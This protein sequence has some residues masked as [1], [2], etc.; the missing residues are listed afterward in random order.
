M[1]TKPTLWAAA[2]LAI[3]TLQPSIAQDRKAPPAPLDRLQ[4][5]DGAR[6]VPD[7]FLRRWDPVTVFFDRDLGPTN[8]GPEDQ[9]DRFVRLDPPQPGAWQ[10]LGAR[11]LQF[12]P[13]EAWQ[14][15]RR[16]RLLLDGNATTLV[17]LLP[18]PRAVGPD[19]ARSGLADFDSFTL[20]F[21]EPVDVASLRRLLSVEIRPLPGIDATGGQVLSDRDYEIKVAERSDRAGAQTYVVA[22]RQPIADGQVAILRLKLADE[23]GLDEPLFEMR[24]QS[25]VPFAVTSVDCA[26]RASTSRDGVM[27]CLS[28]P[29]ANQ[30]G[31]ALGLTAP[32]QVPDIVQARDALRITPPVDDLTVGSSYGRLQ[33]FGRFKTDTLYEIEIAAGALKDARG[34]PLARPLASTKFTF[35]GDEPKLAWD[36]NQGIVERLG[37]QMVPLRGRGYERADIR[38]HPI[39]GLSRDFWPFPSGRVETDDDAKPPLPGNEPDG[40]KGAD[41]IRRD[42]MVARIK[43]LGSPAVSELVALPIQRG[44]LEAKFG[45]DLKPLLS[46]IAGPDQPGTYLVGIRAVDGGPRRWVRIQVTDLVLSGVEEADRVRFYATSLASAAPVAQAELRLEGVDSN[47]RFTT[48]AR[49]V[50]EA[51]GSFTWSSPNAKSQLRR[52]V[53]TKGA[54]TL[55]LE[56]GRAP[57]QYTRENW[58]KTD[59]NWLSW[60][61]GGVEPRRE[62]VQTL[63]HV[64]T[65]RPIY[66]PEEP[67]HIK[68][69]VRRYLKGGLN[70]ASTEGT[71]V[72]NG[73]GD[74]EWRLPVSLDEVGGF[75]QK[76]DQ[77]TEATGDYSVRFEPKNGEAC[78][79]ITFKKEAYRLP[80]FEVLL[81]GPQ[82]VPLDGQ[83][84]VDM[85]ARYFAGGLVAGRPIKWRATQF[86]YAWTPPKRDGFLFSTDSR[87][88]GD[89]KFRS[90]P[91]LER[92][93]KTDDGGSAKLTLDPT[94]EPTAQPRRYV[95]EATVT[96]EDDIQVRNTQSIVALPPFVLGVKIPRYLPKPGSIE[97]EFLA[98][99][100]NGEAIEGVAMTLRLI[101]RNW[102][103]VLQAS[104]FSQGSAKY[105]TEVIDETLAE[106]KIASTKEVQKALFEAKEAG[107]YLVELEAEDKLGRKQSVSID[108]FMAGDTPVTWSKPPAKT[109]TVTS[110]KDEYAPGESATL[111]VQ[112]PFQTGRAL[113]V[114][115]DPSGRFRYDWIDIANGFGRYQVT[116]AKEQMP[117]LAVHFLLMR[118]RLND[119][120][121]GP[122]A[123]FDL[124]KPVTLAATKWVTVTAVKHK[125]LVAFD[126]PSKARPA[127]EVE[128]VLKL[129]DDTGAPVAG[130]ATFWMVDQA[131][132]SLAR[133]QPLDPLPNF[134]VARPTRM[135]ARDSRNMAFGIIPLEEA[136][137]GDEAVDDWGIE[138][139]SVRKNF[140][141][142][143]IYL[144]RVKVGPDGIA[145]IKVKLPDTL[146]VY[147][148]RA[149]AI[150]GPDRFGFGTGEM[151]IRQPVVAQPALPR[152][153]RSGD[154]FEAGLI[155]RIV[156]GPGGTGKGAFSGTNLTIE[157][158]REQAF[159]WTPNQPARL[160]FS[161]VAGE[162]GP[163]IDKSLIRFL[164]QRDADKAADAVEIALPIRPDRSVLRQ[165]EIRDLAPSAKLEI[166]PPAE[167]ARPGTY[168]RGVTLAGDPALARMIGGLN[169]LVE[170]PY[171]C[172]EQRIALASAAL[173]LKPFKAILD[174]SGLGDQ[175]SADVKLALRSID[176]AIDDD[177]LVGFW[178]RSKG[179]VSLTAWAFGF[180]TAAERAGEPVDAAL[181]DR[182]AKV[183]KQALR[184]D[185]PRLLK[186]EELRE[187]VEALSALADA[188]QIDTAYA[189]ELARRASAMP[190]PTLAQAIGAVARLPVADKRLLAEM[191]D[192]MWGR[193][194]LVQRN[195]KPSY[196]GLSDD[197]PGNPLILPSETRTLAEITQA[198]ALA[199]PGDDRLTPVRDGL[200]RLGDGDGWGSTNANAAAL[201]A[202]ATV[203]SAPKAPT[204]IALTLPAGPETV[205]LGSAAP[206]IR[207]TT[208]RAAPIS[209]EN[210]GRDP[211][212]A[213]VDTRYLPVE[214]GDKAKARADGF[215]VTRGSYRVVAGKPLEKLAAEPDGALHLAVGEVIED[216]A[217]L[218]VPEDRTHVALRMPLAAGLE[219]LNPNLATAP[220]EAAPSAPP[221]LAPTW[222]AYRDDE[223]LFVYNEL[224]KGNYRFAVRGRAT[225]P[226]S[227]TQPPAEAE[228]MY[229]PGITGSSDGARLVVS[230]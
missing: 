227:F 54:D 11:T 169:Y 161:A 98:T 151:Q 17:P 79:K 150:S 167:A 107:V 205:S 149:K 155:G 43:A 63:C 28:V 146:T 15:L 25:A 198:I 49:G 124:G 89:A 66:R 204:P 201:K 222:V 122:T 26:S 184:S 181:K 229:R 80:T 143:P 128:V 121:P 83:F 175:V 51:D 84:A 186:G 190:T 172:T 173:A 119:S 117:K 141:P 108:V 48:L 157:G 163:G 104:D 129:T 168:Q 92:D 221:T 1:M 179:T 23:A 217:E 200:V 142:I 102:N 196:A 50:T 40:W 199:A 106:R 29:G 64:F 215:V 78:G 87:F 37:P 20:T 97:P 180:V 153:L 211:V 34:R 206:A 105:V 144:P 81:N 44:G 72:V 218:V 134:V 165:R 52:I 3:L 192:G 100:A 120:Q 195:G 177:G 109:V 197:R 116:V 60:A 166:A 8:G 170:Y 76:F 223:V 148:L 212:L 2:A 58:G 65:E 154:R 57:P 6:I 209:L 158:A 91:V 41:D 12:R 187:R 68:G 126:A 230:R 225:V 4:R 30:R 210:R 103:S 132:L 55:V 10:W 46:K 95:V 160:A 214:R 202:L 53:L 135:A 138:N 67:V 130:E 114:V 133:E 27:T 174:A 88:S 136:P 7:R 159:S 131:V 185:Y 213:L 127:D 61:F 183:L 74:Q 182:L 101:R 35:Q 193:V 125:V 31:I 90:T 137:G 115:E 9:P 38:I 85:T 110:D 152:F 45:L 219:P 189:A 73:P 171:G 86:P 140:T 113:A 19:D 24:R 33:L 188:G 62:T 18:T 71:V 47:N 118:G 156:E 139:I 36:A 16:V 22:L 216:V 208:D 70:Y 191:V 96:G 228:A 123:P 203:W 94:I 75:Y 226:G 14:P 178:P 111:V 176:Q 99:D 194:R 82:Q 77:K 5:A 59:D 32:P 56:P 162:A 112:S 93:G 21:D 69:M 39:D 224:P 164:I 145:R 147:K 220:A 42:G 207:R 13:A